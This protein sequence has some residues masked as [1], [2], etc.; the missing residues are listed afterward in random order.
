MLENKLIL[1]KSQKGY[2]RRKCAVWIRNCLLLKKLAIIILNLTKIII[3]L[4]KGTL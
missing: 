1:L 4:L 2:I 3:K